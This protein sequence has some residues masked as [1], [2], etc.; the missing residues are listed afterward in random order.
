MITFGERLK[1]LRNLKKL[2][3]QQLADI[4][5]LNKS[6]I[7]RYENNGQMPENEVLQK[8][9]DFFEVSIDY[10]LGRTAEQKPLKKEFKPELTTKDKINIEKETEKMIDNLEKVEIIEFCGHIADQ[11][12]KEYFKLA[13]ER[14]LTDVRIYNKQ[15]YTPNRY[16]K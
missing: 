10:L 11:E 7:S 13:Y 4:F 1:E 16:K 8:L 12:D 6:S 2:T 15:K 3:Q 9:A 5:Y 14:F